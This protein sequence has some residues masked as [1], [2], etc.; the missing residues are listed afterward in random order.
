MGCSKCGC[1]GEERG[2]ALWLLWRGERDCIVAAVERRE[3]L[4]CG[5]CGEE[6][7]AA[8]SVGSLERRVGL[9]CGCGGEER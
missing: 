8:V 5:C 9:Q 1:C 4:H 7:W 3:G 6:R 2:T